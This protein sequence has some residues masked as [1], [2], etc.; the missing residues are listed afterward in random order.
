MHK[1]LAIFLVI[2]SLSSCSNDPVTLTNTP[3]Y[4]LPDIDS[5]IIDEIPSDTNVDLSFQVMDWCR[6][7]YKQNTG[8]TP[9]SNLD[10]EEHIQGVLSGKTVIVDPGHGGKDNGAIV[11]TIKEK[12]INREVSNYLIEDLKNAGANVIVTRKDDESLYLYDR[13]TLT[14]LV[15][16]IKNYLSTT[17]KDEKKSIANLIDSLE[18]ILNDETDTIPYLYR[19][20]DDM[21]EDLKMIFELTNQI[22]D[23]VFVSIHSNVKGG[24]VV[25]LEGLDI[26]LSGNSLDSLYP[27]YNLYNDEDRELFGNLLG[28]NISKEVPIDLRKV[29]FGDYAVLREENLPSALIELGYMDDEENLELLTNKN[30]QMKYAQGITNAI[31]EYF[32]Q[33]E[34]VS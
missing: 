18:Q 34:K 16:L 29:Y 33:K 23:T 12:D 15:I 5:T 22:D 4:T 31:I 24:S 25:D 6:I 30:T 20:T 13:P 28:E 1:F 21:N 19:K 14:N 9:C 27:G 11:D 3:L 8:Y 17:D 26:I 2:T 10:I 32:N 7:I